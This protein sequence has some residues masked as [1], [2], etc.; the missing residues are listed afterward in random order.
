MS[1][2]NTSHNL[3]SLRK[4]TGLTQTDISFLLSYQDG[5]QISNLEN[6]NIGASLRIVFA[7]QVLFRISPAGLFPKAFNEIGKTIRDRAEILTSELEKLPAS[8]EKVR[9]IA[10]L[11]AIAAGNKAEKQPITLEGMKSVEK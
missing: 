5:S 6:G 3:Q 8:P 7:Y 4:S 1:R 2:N 11:K 10:V 9:R